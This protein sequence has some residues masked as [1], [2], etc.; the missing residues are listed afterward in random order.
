MKLDRMLTMVEQCL[1]GG[2]LPGELAT[3]EAA[4]TTRAVLTA[5]AP[6]LR[7]EV[8]RRLAAELPLELCDALGGPPCEPDDPVARVAR[9][10]E[11]DQ[12]AAERRVCCVVETLRE[13]VSIDTFCALPDE[14]QALAD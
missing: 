9:E 11:L 14:V 2:C 4:R 3:D 12:D 10:L 5:I 13:A 8:R 7:P 1:G 6:R